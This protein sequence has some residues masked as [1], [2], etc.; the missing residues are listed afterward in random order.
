MLFRLLLIAALLYLVYLAAIAFADAPWQIYAASLIAG[1]AAA[2]L[3]SL[4]ISYLLD[5][6]RDRPGLSASLLSVNMFLGGGLGAGV[7]ALGTEI[8]GYTATAILSGGIGVIGAGLLMLLERRE[9]A[10]DHP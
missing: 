4:P 5:L 9:N 6:I 10:T 3:V 2:A 8:G 1:F 7:F